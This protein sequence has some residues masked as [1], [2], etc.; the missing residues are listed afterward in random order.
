MAGTVI[1][2]VDTRVA[3]GSDLPFSQFKGISYLHHRKGE[4]RQQ[5]PSRFIQGDPFH[6]CRGRGLLGLQQELGVGLP[7]VLAADMGASPEAKVDTE[8]TYCQS[9][10]HIPERRPGQEP[11][12]WE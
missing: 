7:A 11:G 6:V 3:L 4:N 10:A 1:G 9:Q 8:D 5:S 2:T 12:N